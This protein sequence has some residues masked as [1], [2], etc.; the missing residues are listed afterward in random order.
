VV[1]INNARNGFIFGVDE[2]RESKIIVD[3]EMGK[4]SAHFQFLGKKTK[5]ENLSL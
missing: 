3:V 4:N 2:M 5:L 1:F